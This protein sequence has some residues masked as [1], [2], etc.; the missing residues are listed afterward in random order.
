MASKAIREAQAAV[1]ALLAERATLQAE[2][3]AAEAARAPL[4]KKVEAIR[5]RRT[6]VP[7]VSNTGG[8]LWLSS[9][10]AFTA[11]TYGLRAIA[12]DHGV[13][14]KLIAEALASGGL[15]VSAIS[16]VSLT[17]RGLNGRVRS[18]ESGDV[19]A[20]RR[21]VKARELADKKAR[22]AKNRE[23]EAMQRVFDN[24]AKISTDDLLT[25]ILEDAVAR[26]RKELSPEP[27]DLRRRIH[28]LDSYENAPLRVAQ[29]HLDFAKS[30]STEPCPCSTCATDRQQAIRRRD[31]DARLD[32][33]P[34]AMSECPRHPGRHRVAVEHSDLKVDGEI[35]R[36]LVEKEPEL[37]KL[38][39]SSD[40]WPQ[41]VIQ[42]PRGWCRKGDEAQ[43]FIRTAV[44]LAELAKAARQRKP[45]RIGL[46]WVCPNPECGETSAYLPDEQGEI[47]CLVC[48]VLY[49]AD[50]VKTIKPGKA[51]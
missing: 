35:R 3:D 33:L 21:A 17:L 13:K 47:E 48:G 32:G 23:R 7:I 6:R 46:D 41:A 27:H 50:V 44:L 36:R 18:P 30:G 8:Q 11:E 51:A 26:A 24:G 42:A 43:P 19:A 25:G 5:A 12:K 28:D 49:D 1:D 38:L 15:K 34:T 14:P 16:G 10:A 37:D 9:V 22:E 40:I 4:V 45:R 2:L 29:R 20:F 31:L 39:P